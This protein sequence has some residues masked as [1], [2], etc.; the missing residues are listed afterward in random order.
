MKNLIIIGAGGHGK[1]VSRIAKETNNWKSIVFLDS[2]ASFINVLDMNSRKKF[3]NDDFFVAIGDIKKRKEIYNQLKEEGFS[4]PFIISKN[5]IVH[6]N[7]IG[8]GSIV[9]DGAFIN[10]NVNI[11]EAVI[12]NSYSLIE[13]DCNISNFVNIS[14][15]VV[16]GG[17]SKVGA[18]TFIGINSTLSN[19]IDISDNVILGA[20]SVVIKSISSPGTYVGQPVRQSLKLSNDL[21]IVGAGGLGNSVYWT[22]KNNGQWKNIFFLDDILT[23]EDNP[24]IVGTFNDREKFRESEF[25]VAEGTNNIRKKILEMLIYENFKVTKLISKL[26]NI[27]SSKI[28]IGSIVLNQVFINRNCA[29][30]KGVI[31]HDH[32]YIGHDCVFDDYTHISP[33]VSIA[34]KVKIGKNSLIGIASTLIENVIISDNIIIEASSLVLKELKESGTYAGLPLKKI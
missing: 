22:A 5:A 31:I 2:N 29:I 21:I 8:N 16:I 28:D 25:I 7:N 13:H 26:S 18:E 1:V 24:L 17:K 27:I 14:S 9:M 3:I 19:N 30:G 34:G 12:V 15:R 10:N 33:S 23:K 20:S 32:V 6:L 11:G 4:L